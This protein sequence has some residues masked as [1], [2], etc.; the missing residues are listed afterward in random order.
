MIAAVVTGWLLAGCAADA[1]L[2]TGSAGEMTVAQ[3][4]NRVFTVSQDVLRGY[5]FEIDRVDRRAGLIQTFPMT[6]KS[7][8]E[9]HRKDA[10]T[11]RDVIEST[12]QTIYRQA[13][14][15]IVAT[16]SDQWGVNVRVAVS[17]SDRRRLQLT[18]TSQA[19]NLFQLQRGHRRYEEAL[20]LAGVDRSPVELPDD[21]ILAA[22]I[23]AEIDKRLARR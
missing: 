15:E 6:G 14:V 7:W 9:F 18:N 11:V 19:I 23:Q 12:L 17:R 5:L 3:R 16:G 20:G 4:Y 22:K 21:G 10:A 13:I 8:F 2:Q 1:R